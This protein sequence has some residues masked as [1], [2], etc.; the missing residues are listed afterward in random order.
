MRIITHVSG[1]VVSLFGLGMLAR[2]LIERW[3]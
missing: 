1:I 3:H 2:V